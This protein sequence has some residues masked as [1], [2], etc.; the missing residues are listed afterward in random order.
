[1]RRRSLA[2]T[3][4]AFK[5][6]KHRIKTAPPGYRAKRW[7]ELTRAVTEILIEELKGAKG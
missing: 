2:A 1:M 4:P 5:R 6:A 7:R 3:Y